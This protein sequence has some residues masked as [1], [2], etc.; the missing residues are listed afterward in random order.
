MEKFMTNPGQAPKIEVIDNKEEITGGV[1]KLAKGNAQE[2][3]A[4]GKLPANLSIGCIDGRRG[5]EKEENIICIPGGGFGILADTLSA[6]ADIKSESVK[7]EDFDKVTAIVK[8]TLGGKISGHTDD[9]ASGSC[10]A[11]CG[12]VN[13]ALT[14]M[15]YTINLKA[16]D[17]LT[18]LTGKVEND[19][20][21][22][23]AKYVGAHNEVAVLA[24]TNL[25][26]GS[27]T[28]LNGDPKKQTFVYNTGWHEEILKAIAEKVKEATGADILETLQK[29][30]D[31]NFTVTANKLTT[32][33][34]AKN[35]V[36]I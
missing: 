22:P 5:G 8:E 26:D 4:T 11:G 19:P 31:Q 35:K 9:H 33:I 25:E 34:P 18:N 29:T 13:G 6:F 17:F 23:I 3:K 14:N 27:T 2:F 30:K 20:E 24:I 1:Y 36:T 32:N 21:Y 28:Y 7:P 12:H 15:A 10:Y 16:K